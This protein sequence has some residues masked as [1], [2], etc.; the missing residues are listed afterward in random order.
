MIKTEHSPSPSHFS[1]VIWSL[2]IA[3]GIGLKIVALLTTQSLPDGDEAV[4]GLMAIRILKD[5]IHPI[6]P[7]GINYGAG[8]G[9]EAHV[10][11]LI[12]SITGP[13]EV[14]LKS[15]GLFHFLLTL[16]LVAG[17]TTQ[18]RDWPT[19][20]RAA[21]LFAL[22][23][24]T[25]QW[26]LKTA[27]GHQVAVVFA[28]A[29]W[30]C[31]IR[32]WR[33]GAIVLLPLAALAHPIVLPF[34]GVMCLVVI[35]G[36]RSWKKSAIWLAGLL[37]VCLV[38][39]SLLQPPT[40]TVWNP[41]AKSFDGFAILTSCPRLAIGLFA[42]NLNRL[43]MPMGGRFLVALFWLVAVIV[44]A[45]Q[46]QQTRWALLALLAP[47]GILVLVSSHELAARHLLVASPIACLVLACGFSSASR[48][49]NLLFGCLIL[50]GCL[51]HVADFYDPCI[52]GPGAQS[53]GVVRSNFS[54][55]MQE[56]SKQEIRGVYCTDPM[57]QWNIVFASREKIPARWVTSTDRVPEYVEAVDAARRAGQPVALVYPANQ[58]P[59]I[60]F[61]VIAHPADR[62]IDQN[63]QPSRLDTH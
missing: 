7:F 63:F 19:A 13:S 22:A 40:R 62:L 32:N 53:L 10:A 14:G 8:A 24:Q 59:P 31:L 39:Y 56:L 2:V 45:C 5:G 37:V 55:V 43:G 34:V 4:E 52:Y 35:F 17:V 41:L 9:W 47:W 23:P 3:V 36:E 49:T 60:Q 1:N 57:L 11:A 38:E 21:G 50:A 20:L 27:G 16:G 15:V 30:W 44:A 46:R 54:K 51:V 28:L 29:G 42:S 48:N 12:F 18:L 58:N 33:P 25:A 26:A 6:Y 61:S